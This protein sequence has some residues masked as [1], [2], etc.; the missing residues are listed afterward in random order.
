[1]LIQRRFDAEPAAGIAQVSRLLR[2]RLPS[3]LLVDFRL[4]DGTGLELLQQLRQDPRT[5]KL[6]VLMLASAFQVE[7]YRT[8]LTGP[9][10]QNWL[11]KPVEEER[12]TAAVSQWVGAV[13]QGRGKEANANSETTS[14]RVLTDRGSFGEL[15]FA[16]VLALAGRRAAGQLLIQRQ[17]NW[18]RLWVADN[19]INGLSSSFLSNASLGRLLLR[20]G[21]ISRQTLREAEAEISRGKRLGRWLIEHDFLTE[22]ELL[23]N[24][25]QQVMEKLQDVFSWRWHDATWNYKSPDSTGDIQVQ[26]DVPIREIIFTGITNFYNRERLEMIFSK[27]HRLRRPVIPTS[28]YSAGLPVAAKRLLAA[29]D[30]RSPSAAVRQRAGMEVPRFYQTLYA[31]WVLDLVRLGEPL[32]EE[33]AGPAFD[34]D[35]F[36]DT[37][38]KAETPRRG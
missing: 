29:A 18:L 1:M 37:P 20:E 13:V 36:L 22:S 4:A 12:L 32:T 34:N 21:R 28:P 8:H 33:Q 2:R 35:I 38:E 26:C 10:P 14:P 17:N 30:G 3:L 19:V 6:P 23:V 15:P 24:L 27:R 31:L 7:H 5:A 9:A 11:V 16:R 25:H